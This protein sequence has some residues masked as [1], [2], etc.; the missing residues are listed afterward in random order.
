[1]TETTYHLA[2][3]WKD[4]QSNCSKMVFHLK[5]NGGPPSILPSLLG[6]VTECE[7]FLGPRQGE[8]VLI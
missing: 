1:M 2:L 8:E 5:Q 4:N 6:W 7:I 3:T